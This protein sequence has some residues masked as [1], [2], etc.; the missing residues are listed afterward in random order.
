MSATATRQHVL[1]GTAG[2]IDHGKTRLV[3][4][5]TGADTDRLPEEKARGISIDLGFAHWDVDEFRFGIVDVPG[6][7]RFVKNMVAGATGINIALLVVAADD[8]VMPQTREHLEIMNLLGVQT[9]VVAVTKTDLVD[10]EFTELVL[11]EIHDLVSGTFLESAPILPVSS[12]TGAGIEALRQALRDAARHLPTLEQVDYFRMP[13][14]RAFSL[15]GHGSVVT[16]SALSGHVS[17][18]DRLELLPEQKL[19]RVRSVEHHHVSSEELEQGAARQRTAVNLA[20]IKLDELR[21]GQELAT[22]HVLAPTQ[23]VVVQLRVLPEAGVTFK[24]RTNWSLHLGTCEV[25]ARVLLKGQP[26][27]ADGQCFAELR[28]RESFV[29]A[30]GQRFILRGGSPIRTIAG[31]VV[32][33][34]CVPRGVRIRDLSGHAR[35]LQ[36]EDPLERLAFLLSQS[37]AVPEEAGPLVARAGLRC[38]AYASAIETLTSRQVLRSVSRSGRGPLFHAERLRQLQKSVM[39]VI[40][41]AVQAAHPRRSLPFN[42]LRNHCRG[43]ADDSL[44]EHLLA[45]LVEEGELVRVGRNL[46]PA[47]LQVQLSRNQQK[48]LE[49]LL[50]DVTAA[51]LTP[52]TVKEFAA[53]YQQRPEQ[54]ASLLTVADEDGRL[55]RISDEFSMAPA[56]LDHARTLCASVFAAQDEATLSELRK[57]WGISRKYAIPLGEYFDATAVTLREGD[58]RKAG[59]QLHSSGST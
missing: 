45:M 51:G 38:D 9:G 43:L 59:P 40:R 27:P 31:G 50:Q 41:E 28:T 56:A 7:E 53:Q 12:E 6:H 34:P 58:L 42:D 1:I 26:L 57:A 35:A 3:G 13:I 14:D 44:L 49:Q 36:H 46:G 19:V 25:T 54:I 55:I 39:R 32:L 47:D 20:G 18:G 2:H 11:S 4:R 37:D 29:A 5:L 52:P 30:C 16:G 15:P 8:G 24:D 21:R 17:A 23:R 22:P 48:L 10:A 33:D